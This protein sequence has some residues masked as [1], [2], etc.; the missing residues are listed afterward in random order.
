MEK[1]N[2][3]AQRRATASDGFTVKIPTRMAYVRYADDFCPRLM[4]V[5][6]MGKVEL[7]SLGLELNRDKTKVTKFSDG[8][9]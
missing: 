8:I 6:I 7:D 5:D 3:N 2:N 4:A 9:S 1:E